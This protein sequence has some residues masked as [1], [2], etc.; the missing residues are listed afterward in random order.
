MAIDIPPGMRV[1]RDAVVCNSWRPRAS[2]LATEQRH[3]HSNY[4][5]DGLRAVRVPKRDKRARQ[6]QKLGLVYEVDV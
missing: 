5:R 6:R 4:N 1:R 2:A 3:L